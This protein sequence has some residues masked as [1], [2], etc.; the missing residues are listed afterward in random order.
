[1][2]DVTTVCFPGEHAS[3]EDRPSYDEIIQELQEAGPQQDGLAKAGCPGSRCA[4][5]CLHR[6]G[7]YSRGDCRWFSHT[8]R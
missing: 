7:R 4:A 6:G 5:A 3:L 2:A 8:A 1:M